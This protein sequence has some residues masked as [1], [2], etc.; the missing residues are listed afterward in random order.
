MLRDMEVVGT[1]DNLGDT[2]HAFCQAD[3]PTTK[4]NHCLVSL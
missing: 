1:L 3:N 2:L 4:D